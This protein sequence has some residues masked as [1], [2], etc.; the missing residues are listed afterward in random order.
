LQLRFF[1]VNIMEFLLASLFFIYILHWE[2]GIFYIYIYIIYSSNDK[3]SMKKTILCLTQMLPIYKQRMLHQ[4][5]GNI[6]YLQ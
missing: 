3:G 6:T 2:V 4:V 1:I 5:N